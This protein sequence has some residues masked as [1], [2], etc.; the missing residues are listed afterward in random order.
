MKKEP[1]TAE[2]REHAKRLVEAAQYIIEH[3][4]GRRSE[5]LDWI[6]H[7]LDN[8]DTY[9]ALKKLT[10]GKREYEYIKPPSDKGFA[11]TST[12]TAN[13]NRATL[14]LVDAY[15]TLTETDNN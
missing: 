9:S 5:R 15:H 3:E 13:Y 10:A 12:A 1:T 14:Y 4:T 2:R 11:D 6:T 7:D 8:G